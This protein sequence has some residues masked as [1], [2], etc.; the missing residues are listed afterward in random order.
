MTVFEIT[1]FEP[2]NQEIYNMLK[3]HK[4]FKIITDGIFGDRI[5]KIIYAS[6]ITGIN[7]ELLEKHIET[8]SIVK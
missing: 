8:I 4:N 1:L 7:Y 5:R 2:I 6:Q 3:N